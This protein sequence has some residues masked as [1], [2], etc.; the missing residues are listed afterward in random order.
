[1][2]VKCVSVCVRVG[3][4][5]NAVCVCTLVSALWVRDVCKWQVWLESSIVILLI[6]HHCHL[7]SWDTQAW[8]CQRVKWFI[9][10]RS[11]FRNLS[12]IKNIIRAQNLLKNLLPVSLPS[13][14][15][16]R[17][18]QRYFWFLYYSYQHCYLP[19]PQQASYLREQWLDVRKGRRGSSEL[20]A[21]SQKQKFSSECGLTDR[22]Q[23][24]RAAQWCCSCDCKLH[25][26]V[27]GCSFLP[28]LK[29]VNTICSH[30]YF[31]Y[32]VETRQ[33][34]S[35]QCEKKR[36]CLR[37]VAHNVWAANGPLTYLD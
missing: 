3:G 30:H 32:V 22:K 1:M 28:F 15:L 37:S 26:S 25:R 6:H 18:S 34:S 2:C 19:V 17:H 11:F 20:S 9:T 35:L 16:L 29:Y 7:S 13:N 27:C 5:T 23:H 24:K 4:L 36:L 12:N 21:L 8:I 31:P 10:G 14:W 33:S